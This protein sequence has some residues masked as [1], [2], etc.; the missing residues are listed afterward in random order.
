VNEQ[1][2][3]AAPAICSEPHGIRLSASGCVAGY[4]RVN[5]ISRDPAQFIAAARALVCRELY[6][7]GMNHGQEIESVTIINPFR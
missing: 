1:N 6:F 7:E 3:P 4:C 5:S 2:R